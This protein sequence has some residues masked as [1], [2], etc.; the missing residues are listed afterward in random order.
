[1]EL[2][3]Y[4]TLRSLEDDYWW[5][6]GL[7]DLLLALAGR[8]CDLSVPLRI[9]DAGCGTGGTLSFLAK[10]LPRSTLFGVDAEAVAVDLARSREAGTVV[11]AS[12]NELPFA[13]AAFDLVVCLDVLYFRGV[14]ESRALD[15]LA[16]VLRSAGLAVINVPAYEFLRGEHDLAVDT[17][18]RYTA[19][20][21]RDALERAGFQ[22][23]ATTYWNT[24]LFPFIVAWRRV[25]RRPRRG[26][27]P[28]SDLWP[29]PRWLN[30]L[31]TRLITKE[32]RMASRIP[33]P[34]GI[35]IM[36][37]AKKGANGRS[38]TLSPPV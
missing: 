22:I 18:H 6:V 28:T 19:K 24:L 26:A 5:Y 14:E 25:R 20:E 29:L 12:V 3:E 10:A 33:L 35:S 13:S 17:R 34:F 31:L 1:M 38:H 9:L 32:V 7:R 27:A 4:S 36:A 30:R 16:R 23:E 37:I 2:H 21:L 15:E 8:H 11:R